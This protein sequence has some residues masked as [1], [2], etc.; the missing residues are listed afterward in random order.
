MSSSDCTE[1]HVGDSTSSEAVQPFRLPAQ[2]PALVAPA[3]PSVIHPASVAAPPTFHPVPFPYLPTMPGG[4]YSGYPYVSSTGMFPPGVVPPE[5]DRPVLSH[6]AS[7]PSF[8]PFP[9]NSYY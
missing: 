8:Q 1:S 5:Q 9:I 4:M 7:A 3:V 2:E 6:P